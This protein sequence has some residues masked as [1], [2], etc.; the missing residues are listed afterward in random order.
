MKCCY[1]VASIFLSKHS[2]NKFKDNTFATFDVATCNEVEDDV[3]FLHNRLIHTNGQDYFE[4]YG[5]AMHLLHKFE[6]LHFIKVGEL[7]ALEPSLS[8]M[9][10][11]IIIKVSFEILYD[12]L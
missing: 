3:K 5:L 9:D 4:Y 8:N 6:E 7:G 2:F 12:D 10:I 1:N 11:K